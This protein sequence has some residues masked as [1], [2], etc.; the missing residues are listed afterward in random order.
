MILTIIQDDITK[1][2]VDAIVNAAN[3]SLMGG[4]GVDGAIHRVAGVELKK[5]CMEIHKNLYPNGLPIGKAVY[6]K[7]FNLPAKYVIHTVGHTY[8]PNNLEKLKQCYIECLT[9]AEKLGCT[10]IAFPAISTGAFRVPI[11]VSAKIV[12]EVLSDFK[13]PFGEIILVL[14]S[15]KDKEVYE[16]VFSK[17][18]L[19]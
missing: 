14:F 15:A 8:S 5:E 16:S 3:S 13:T 9:L 4:G 10:T 1:L 18:V 11:E 19:T 7:G 6:T 2:K 17:D 12:K